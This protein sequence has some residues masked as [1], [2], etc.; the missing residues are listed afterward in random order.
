MIPGPGSPQ[1]PCQRSG[2]RQSQRCH[3]PVPPRCWRRFGSAHVPDHNRGLDLSRPEP[4]PNILRRAQSSLCAHEEQSGTLGFRDAMPSGL[5]RG[6]SR[7]RVE[8]VVDGGR[9]SLAN[10]DAGRSTAARMQPKSPEVP[11]LASSNNNCSEGD[12]SIQTPRGFGKSLPHTSPASLTSP[13]NSDTSRPFFHCRRAFPA[14]RV[15]GITHDIERSRDSSAGRREGQ[16]SHRSTPHSRSR[17]T[18]VLE[19]RPL[20]L[21]QSQRDRIA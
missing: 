21:E 1:P 4:R 12:V 18:L 14:S 11:C 17:W 5:G 3:D 10:F 13:S 6:C 19:T 20:R 7:K 15:P 8:A 2:G 16:I 9:E